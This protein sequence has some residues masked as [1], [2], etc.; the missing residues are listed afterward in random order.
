MIG[1]RKLSLEGLV[2][3][4]AQA[5][6]RVD[7]SAP[8]WT[9]STGRVYQAGLGPHAEDAPV[10]LVLAELDDD[11]DWSSVQCGQFIDYPNQPGQGCDLSF[12]EPLQMTLLVLE[13]ERRLLLPG[14]GRRTEGYG[15]SSPPLRPPRS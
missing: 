9:S 5:F 6:A 15:S 1:E 13:P 12:G 2:T 14:A 10:A 7:A 3:A 8:V 11:P 4:F